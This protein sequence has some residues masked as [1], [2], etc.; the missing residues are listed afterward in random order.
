MSPYSLK[1]YCQV[2][3]GFIFLVPKYSICGLVVYIFM[4]I[5]IEEDYLNVV[6]EQFCHCIIVLLEEDNINYVLRCC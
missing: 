2:Y 3:G 5:E 1:V 4:Y 6:V